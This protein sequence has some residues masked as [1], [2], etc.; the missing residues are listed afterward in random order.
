[1]ELTSGK[2]RIEWGSQQ[3]LPCRPRALGKGGKG[4]RDQRLI[5][6]NFIYDYIIDYGTEL[7]NLVCHSVENYYT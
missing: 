2:S 4:E 6:N 5:F 7:K 1:M 3:L